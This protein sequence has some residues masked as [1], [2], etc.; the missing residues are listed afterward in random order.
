[1]KH[2]LC[3]WGLSTSREGESVGSVLGLRDVSRSE[4]PGKSPR[5]FSFAFPSNPPWRAGASISSVTLLGGNAAASSPQLGRRG[6]GVLRSCPQPSPGQGRPARAA[7]LWECLPR[8]QDVPALAGPS[9]ARFPPWE[10]PGS[11]HTCVLAPGLGS[12]PPEK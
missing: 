12:R 4:G 1:M 10:L 3:P 11:D 8:S 2:C 9:Q 6:T 5:A 7:S